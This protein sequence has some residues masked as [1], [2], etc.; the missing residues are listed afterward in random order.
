MFDHNQKGTGPGA[1]DKDPVD[2]DAALADLTTD[3]DTSTGTAT[4]DPDAEPAQ[5]VDSVG[6]QTEPGPTR[7]EAR[8]ILPDWARSKQSM[9]TEAKRVVDL[10]LH[11]TAYHAV[12]VPKYGAK[13]ALRAPVGVYRLGGHVNRWLWDSEGRAVR[14]AAVARQD[15][16]AYR[17][18][19][20]MRDRHVRWRGLVVA[21]GLTGSVIGAG[22][23]YVIGGP[24]LWA[25]LAAATVGFG[26]AGAPADKP[27]LD[28]AVVKTSL[29][30]LTSDVVIRGLSVLGISGINQAVSKLGD[31][32]IGFTSPITRD[33]PGWRA[34]VDL[35]WGVTAG[36]VADK[37]DK[38]ASGL[39]RP[40]G[41]VWPEGR[42]EITPGRLVVWV[43]DEDMATAKQPKWPYIRS[44]TVDLF[45]PFPLGCDPRGRWVDM[46]LI[47]TNLLIGSIPGMG[48][49]F[50]MRLPLLAAALDPRAELWVYELKGTGDLESLGLVAHRYASGADDPEIEQALQALRDLREECSRRAKV[51]KG[52]PKDI[53]PENKVTP[54]LAS[55]KSL[56]LHPL[57]VAIDECQE[58]F[59]HPEYGAE[60]AELAE[61]CI[62]L[63]RALGIIVI[64]ATQRPD[65]KSLPTGVSANVGTRYCLRVMGQLENDMILGT[66]SYKN[67]IRATMFTSRDKGVGYLVGASDDAQITKTSYIDGP[68]A[69]A[70]CQRA[71]TARA[72]AGRLG[73]YATGEAITVTEKP[74]FDLLADLLSV[75][76]GKDKT[77]WNSVLVDQL[78]ELR[79]DHYGHRWAELNDQEKTTAL[80]AELKTVRADQLVGQVGRRID[81][82]TVNRRGINRDKL[83]EIITLRDGKSGA[84]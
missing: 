69:E 29:S 35:P 80:T 68:T 75:F 60:A 36:E 63:G 46:D 55:K 20:S 25:A 72:A 70:I 43:G 38:L 50:S 8:P 76:A 40:L 15:Y 31:R 21:A 33:G 81:G 41:C 24:I 61:K 64:L 58:L 82:R 84:N 71:R 10:G 26:I 49:T 11:T 18:L 73:G 48:K 1:G 34:E 54:E 52:L 2:W 27:L 14:A 12:R 56:G 32:A 16:E 62:K 39:G 30:P 65:A 79:P 47:Y 23:L 13:L 57:V 3:N 28:T 66:S 59:S 44:G 9:L 74:K 77:E 4:V 53:C 19:A 6:A 45:K 51:I 78:I 17:K 83:R 67:G 42:P 37:R 7:A 22:V 5:R